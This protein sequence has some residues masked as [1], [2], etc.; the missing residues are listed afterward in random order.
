M[1]DL[2]IKAQW[3]SPDSAW[4]AVLVRDDVDWY[5]NGALVGMG[6]TAADAV[7]ELTGLARHL[8]IEGCNFLCRH[9]PMADREW[10]AALLDPA[11]TDIEMRD[12]LAAARGVTRR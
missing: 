9:L 5:L 7:A 1:D 4:A 3:H 6:P 11:G 10:L 2:V 12:A 8:V